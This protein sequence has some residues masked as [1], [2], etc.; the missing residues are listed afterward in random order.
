MEIEGSGPVSG[1]LSFWDRVKALVS[2]S[3]AVVLEKLITPVSDFQ[4]KVVLT[5]KE[6]YETVPS[7]AKNVYGNT[8]Q[9]VLNSKF[10]KIVGVG[11]VFLGVLKVK[12]W[13]K[14]D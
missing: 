9:A 10:L 8:V 5:P 1:G 7:F 11:V 14:N 2:N 13:L 4:N 12:G 3:G 6:I